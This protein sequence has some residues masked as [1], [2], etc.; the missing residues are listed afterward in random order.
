MHNRTLVF[1]KSDGGRIKVDTYALRKMRRYRQKK[2]GMCESGG[3]LLGRH[4]ADSKDIVVD[5]VTTPMRND[6]RCRCFFLRRM[7]S[8]QRVVTRRW[9]ES[10]GSCNYLGEW[11]THPEAS[12]NPSVFDILGWKR[13]LKVTRFDGIC[14][15][16][17]IVG[18]E[19]LKVWEG[20]KH[21]LEIRLLPH[22]NNGRGGKHEI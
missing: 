18:T 1:Q 8:H 17:V 11:H 16:F 5:D 9:R 19:Q 10:R 6:I 2:K 4:I 21:S 15:Y 3:V 7:G 22:V 20:N 13:L 14:L 12:P